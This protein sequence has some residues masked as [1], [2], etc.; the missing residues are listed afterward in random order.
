MEIVE[1][2]DREARELR[3]A[4]RASE[5]PTERAALIAQARAAK[6]EGRSLRRAKA[7]VRRRKK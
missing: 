6:R 5:D 7:R 1:E 3:R 2:L 4:A